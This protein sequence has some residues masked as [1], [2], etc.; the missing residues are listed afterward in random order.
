MACIQVE[1]A[2]ILQLYSLRTTVC[3]HLLNAIASKILYACI[4]N[5]S[6]LM[7]KGVVYQC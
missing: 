7:F 3:I 1:I 4:P 2:P 6:T 5:C